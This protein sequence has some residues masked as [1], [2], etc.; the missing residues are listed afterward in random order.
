[1]TTINSSSPV[2]A[3]IHAQTKVADN[4]TLKNL[5]VSLTT[6]PSI[7]SVQIS[8]SAQEK[9][10]SET[11]SSTKAQSLPPP[12]GVTMMPLG[13]GSGNDPPV[14]PPVVRT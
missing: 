12:I 7:D 11:A 3:R 5:V 13:N 10:K 8:D 6:T 1:M 14:D 2:S 9:L 4:T